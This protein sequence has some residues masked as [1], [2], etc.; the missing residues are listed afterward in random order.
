MQVKKNDD[1]KIY[2]M[3]VLKKKALVKRKQVQH[4]Q[5]VNSTKNYIYERKV[6]CQIDHPFVV[7][8]RYSFQTDAKVCSAFFFLIYLFIYSFLKCIFQSCP[9]R[10][11]FPKK[12]RILLL[13]MILDFFNGGELFFHLK[14]EGRFNEKR[15]K[16]YAAEICSA[17]EC[18]HLKGII[19]R[20]LKPENILLDAEGHIKITD[21]GLSKDC[22]KG[23]MITHTFCGTPEYLAPEVLQG[24]NFVFISLQ[25]VQNHVHNQINQ[26]NQIKFYQNKNKIK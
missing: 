24:D 23:D 6:L 18:L 15:S 13:Y 7:S 26:I 8:L 3:K 14:N 10:F 12:K 11:F 25:F 17:L 20:D 22:L 16:F 19:Y 1:G 4:T 2:A 21:F 9:S 5:T